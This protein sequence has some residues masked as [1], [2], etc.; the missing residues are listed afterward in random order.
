MP[1]QVAFAIQSLQYAVSTSLWSNWVL[2]EVLGQ[3]AQLQRLFQQQSLFP[4]V[5]SRT[6]Q[7]TDTKSLPQCIKLKGGF[8]HSSYFAER[9]HDQHDGEEKNSASS[10]SDD[11]SKAT[12]PMLDAEVWKQAKSATKH[13][14]HAKPEVHSQR[15]KA[16]LKPNKD[17]LPSVLTP[18]NNF[19]VAPTKTQQRC[20]HPR[21]LAQNANCAS[22][23]TSAGAFAHYNLFN[24]LRSRITKKTGESA[25]ALRETRLP[26]EASKRTKYERKLGAKKGTPYCRAFTA[27]GLT[28]RQY[29]IASPASNFWKIQQPAISTSAPQPTNRASNNRCI[30]RT[31]PVHTLPYQAYNLHQTPTTLR[32]MEKRTLRAHRQC[33]H[34]AKAKPN[35][36]T[37]L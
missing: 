33:R 10:K 29:H 27:Q 30:A 1:P 4:R 12:Y 26:D 5:P 28:V 31:A 22:V 34:A 13:V 19:K 24:A 7:P 37:F 36:M 8:S 11:S 9:T 2:L 16:L 20:R 21:A 18:D 15:T 25:D 6:V 14:I 32:R 35:L 23:S 17:S 3:E